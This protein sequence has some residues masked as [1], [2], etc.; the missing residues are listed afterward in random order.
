MLLKY[1]LLLLTIL[2]LA[3]TLP[4][5]LPEAKELSVIEK[6]QHILV[7]W[8]K[9]KVQATHSTVNR[10]AN[11]VAIL[12][13]DRVLRIYSLASGKRVARIEAIP[14][15][16][17]QIAL[18]P[19]GKVLALGLQNRTIAVIQLAQEKV[20]QTVVADANLQL[21][22]IHSLV[23][24]SENLL[25]ALY[26]SSFLRS[27]KVPEFTELQMVN[28]FDR[29]LPLAYAQVQPAGV[30]ESITVLST[31]SKLAIYSATGA[32]DASPRV[33]ASSIA[34]SSTGRL[35]VTGKLNGQIDIYPADSFPS[36]KA[37]L[38][39]GTRGIFSLSF[40]KDESH[41]AVADVKGKL[42]SWSLASGK[43]VFSAGPLPTGEPFIFTYVM[44]D[45]LLLS[46]SKD[47]LRFWD[48]STG[49]AV[50]M[51]N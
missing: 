49:N 23:F 13:T 16:V 7:D 2:P 24:P 3:T 31:A 43:L 38:Q 47:G 41:V 25:S 26:D 22:R 51:Q 44:D 45:A 18:S 29:A 46:V 42:S 21:P 12:G 4:D 30:E 20:V 34:L 33:G 48:S 40:S 10:Q 1:C 6:A 28:K 32:K 27:W 17:T 50:E 36:P 39:V 14:D 8:Q 37:S 35:V 19:Q 15:G 11:I 9:E 5:S